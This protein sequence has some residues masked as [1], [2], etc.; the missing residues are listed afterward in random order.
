MPEEGRHPP[1]WKQGKPDGRHGSHLP[2]NTTRRSHT[3]GAAGCITDSPAPTANSFDELTVLL[4]GDMSRTGSGWVVRVPLN[5]RT[6][7]EINRRVGWNTRCPS[8]D[9]P[10]AKP[11]VSTFPQTRANAC[12]SRHPPLF[13]WV[14]IFYTISP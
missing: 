3:A 13:C 9:R 5:A 6:M 7:G 4:P 1:Y 14:S 10:K 12:G 2:P 8:Q 11:R